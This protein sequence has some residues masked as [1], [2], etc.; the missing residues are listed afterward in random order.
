MH[1][2]LDQNIRVAVDKENPSI[3]RDESLC[4]KCTLCAQLCNDYVG[5]NSAYSLEKSK[6]PICIYC[7]QCINVCPTGSLKI[8][9]STTDLLNA[10]QNPDSV[11]IVSTSPAVRVS[12]GEAFG[13]EAG[14]FT[15]GKMIS[16]LRQL[17]ADYVLD[18]SFAADLTI[19]EEAS[20]LVDRLQNQKNLPQFTS[21]CPAW[22]KYA[23]IFHPE[24]LPYLS[25]AKSPI[26]MQ[27]ATIKTY[28]A[29]KHQLDPKKIVNVALTPCTAKKFEIKRE[30]MNASSQ[31][32]NIEGM[33]DMDIVVTTQELAR[34]AQNQQ[35]DFQA[36]PE[37]QYDTLMGEA[38][39][40]AILFGASGGVMEA[41]LRT[42]HE[43]IIKEKAPLDLLDLKPIRGMDNCKKAEVQIGDTRI[44]VAVIYGT[45]RAG[46]FIEQIKKSDEN[47][48]FIEV[49]TCPG[50]C[51]GGAGQIRPNSAEIESVRE[52]RMQSIYQR[53]A[54][55]TL[56]NSLENPEIQE[57]YK[58]FY[59]APLSEKAKK[60][61]HTH[62]SDYSYQLG[63]KTMTKK[64][65]C[66][67]CGYIYEGDQLPED[68]VCPI[69]KKGIE[70]FEEV[71][72]AKASSAKELG[73]KTARNLAE[74]FAGESQARNKYTYFA[75]VA[76]QEGYEQLAEIFLSTAR[77]EQEH[78]R[79]WFDYLGGI[80]DTAKNLLAAAE[81]EN[82]EWTDMY[83][84]FA[85]DAD[86]EGHPE[87]AAQF[88]LVATIEKTHEERYR[89]LLNNVE[90]KQVFEKSEMCMWECRICGHIVVGRAAP[91]VCPVCHRSQSFFEVR[92][93]NY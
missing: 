35:I 48:H 2:H 50:G 31:Y 3:Q 40:G 42:A 43:T 80:N 88:R 58:N 36:L 66:K 62:Y 53:D 23:E 47:F 59:T 76:Q 20:E 83:D 5:V 49:M 86:E 55:L 92:K 8:K 73:P 4:V 45:K 37:G 1:P 67:V 9:D 16:L 54:T 77:N 39:G 64:Y 70:V 90:M 21:C 6:D 27:G 91:E 13:F 79:L 22:V 81:G 44:K 15:Q 63:E 85:K 12:L 11:V 69:C 56:K 10:I 82:Y 38:S 41:A 65:R 46:E 30:E 18:T 74:A 61:L 29:K 33:R 60:L 28:F 52:A 89:T 34:L 71:K 87:I 14:S 75:E 72:E 25:T 51:L 32:W 78:A 68:Y 57:L 19:M 7:G 93:N 84:R 24:I 17:G 26:G